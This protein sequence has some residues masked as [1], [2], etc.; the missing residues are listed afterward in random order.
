MDI[1]EYLEKLKEQLPSIYPKVSKAYSDF[2]NLNVSMEPGSAGTLYTSEVNQFVDQVDFEI[3]PSGWVVAK[4]FIDDNGLRIHSFPMKI[5][6]GTTNP[7]GFG[8]LAVDW[9]DRVQSY[10]ISKWAER[11]INDYLMKNPAIDW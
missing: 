11:K 2:P 1:I 10:K 8:V 4:P 6:L 7:K 5:Y 9:R 3:C